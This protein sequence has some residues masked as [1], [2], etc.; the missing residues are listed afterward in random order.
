MKKQIIDE[1]TR[2]TE[3]QK[4][5]LNCNFTKVDVRRVLMSTPNEKAPGLDGYN[6]LIFLK[7]TWEIIGD[8]IS[9]VVLD[10]LKLG[11]ILKCINVTSITLIPKVKSLANVSD[12]IG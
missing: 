11:E 3:R 8:D 12:L 10:F 4:R 1:G 7:H 5:M 6:N 9:D 2:L